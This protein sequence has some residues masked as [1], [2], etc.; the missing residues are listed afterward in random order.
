MNVI[1]CNNKLWLYV[2]SDR[3]ILEQ[4]DKETDSAYAIWIEDWESANHETITSFR[5]TSIPSIIDE[6]E[7]AKSHI[8]HQD[9]L[10]TVSQAIHKLVDNET[11]LK[12]EPIS[13][14]TMLLATLAAVP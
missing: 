13:I 3:P 2:S 11:R 10:P 5:N 9:P 7:L 12:T 14:Q 6:F 8:L 4:V 1:Y